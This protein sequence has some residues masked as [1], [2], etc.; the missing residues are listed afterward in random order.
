MKSDSIWTRTFLLLCSAQ[1]FGYAQHAVLTPVLPLYVTYLGGS[2]LMV[3]LVLAAF[4]ATSV[5]VRPVVGHWAD[6]WNEAGVM[7][8]GLLFQGLSIFICFVPLVGAAMLANS[9]RGIGWAG[10][11]TGG[12][13][14]LAHTAPE[15]RRGEASG[16]YS[17]FQS[18]SAILFPAF[19]LWLLQMPVGGFAAVFLASAIFSFAG[20]ALGALMSQG[21]SDT[22]SHKTSRET[23]RQWWREI[24]H[25]IERDILLPST[26]L[27]W[28]NL[29]LP[30]ITNFSVL[31]ARDLGIMNFGIFFIVLGIT[32]L[33]G[34]PFLGRF[35]DRFGRDRSIATGFVLQL[36]ALLLI[37]TAAN[38]FGMTVAGALYMTGNA[39]GSSTTLALAVERADPRR[40]GKAMATFSV[41]YPLSYGVGSL[42][43]GTAVEITG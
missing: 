40:R 16:L 13:S 21:I 12:Y 8:S 1:F 31:Y 39:L 32:S 28:L 35:S 10:L 27:F 22:V 5:I 4:A 30:S 19:A 25:F 14:L 20:A 37:T 17:G 34:R 3:G 6:R 33:V 29:S 9:L 23:T 11:N 24:F 7:I 41:A 36:V 42:I 15:A 2:A 43:T 26:I 38:L 18:A